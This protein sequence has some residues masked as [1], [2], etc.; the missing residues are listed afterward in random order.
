MQARARALIEELQDLSE[1]VALGLN[2][3]VQTAL[4]ERLAPGVN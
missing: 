3:Q 1:T 2:E 4:R